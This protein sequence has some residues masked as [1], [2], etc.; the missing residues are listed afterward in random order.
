ME[1]KEK[2]IKELAGEV[3]KASPGSAPRGL[4][5][6]PVLADGRVEGIAHLAEPVVLVRAPG[7]L[8]ATR[9]AG[10]LAVAVVEARVSPDGTVT[11]G[12]A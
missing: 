3:H 11:P 7:G 10:Q 8:D 12:S 1:K 9:G 5:V 6:G 2:P 4:T